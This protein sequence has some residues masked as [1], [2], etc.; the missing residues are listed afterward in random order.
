MP[1][2]SR[3]VTVSFAAA[4]FAATVALSTRDGALREASAF[5]RPT[6]L[7]RSGCPLGMVPI[8]GGDY[9]LGE[10]KRPAK[11]APYCLDV[12]E[13][14][15]AAYRACVDRGACKAGEIAS[16]YPT[17]NWDKPGRGDH[18]I[19]CPTWYEAEAYCKAV[20][21]RLPTEDEWE[22][23]ARGGSRAWTYAWGNDAK[24]TE[25]WCWRGSTRASR[26]WPESTCPVAQFPAN[27]FGVY[28]L[29][30]NLW[31]WTSTA[32]ADGSSLTGV[33]EAV[34][35]FRGGSWGSGDA[36]Q[37]RADIRGGDGASWRDPE[38]GFRCAS[39]LR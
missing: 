31:E 26:S 15:V 33:S 1:T 30:G 36:I 17:C 28:D 39:S 13:V 7:S 20:G 27:P 38:V 29:S 35:V 9:E 4:L 14:T 8:P 2:R 23:A 3:Y 11:V 10:A 21:K 24:E 18:P 19:N 34:Y 22:W 6:A 16:K 5:M 37:A 25:T 12:H 32:R